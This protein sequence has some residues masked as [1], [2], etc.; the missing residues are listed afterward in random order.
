MT[1]PKKLF[2][3]VSARGQGVVF[4]A[5]PERVEKIG[6]WSGRIEGCYCSVIAD[7]E[8]EGLL[9]LPKLTYSDEPVELKLT[10]SYG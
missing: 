6:V 1:K 8:A 5:K 10:V 3:A 2:Y 4:T 9:R 7:M